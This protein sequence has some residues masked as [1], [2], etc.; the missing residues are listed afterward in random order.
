MNV[1]S[2]AF[3]KY[4]NCPKNMLM[5]HIY[6]SHVNTLLSEDKDIKIYNQ[7]C[8]HHQTLGIPMKTHNSYC[9]KSILIALNP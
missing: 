9:Q 2:Y 5:D 7:I 4:M 8:N 1:S 6:G 3:T